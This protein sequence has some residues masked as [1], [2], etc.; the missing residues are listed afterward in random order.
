[1]N[2]TGRAM[3]PALAMLLAVGAGT[4]AL[5]AGVT[6][7]VKTP[8]DGGSDSNSG[9]RWADAYA[10]IS[11]AVANV[12]DGDS[13]LVSN[14]TYLITSEVLLDAAPR[15]AVVRLRF[16][17]GGKPYAAKGLRVRLGARQMVC[18]KDGATFEDVEPGKHQLQVDRM[19]GF[20]PIAARDVEVGRGRTVE[21][22]IQLERDAI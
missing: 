4:S 12:G 7:H 8:G 10:T 18:S 2:L 21:V 13:I 19:A 3:I 5:A 11:N 17:L 9:D 15:T 14:G 22:V 6:K 20:K 1:M 16:E